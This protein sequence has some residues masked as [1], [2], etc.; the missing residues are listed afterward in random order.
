[1]RVFFGML[2]GVLMM[3]MLFRTLFGY[4]A[5]HRFENAIIFHR[6]V[7]SYKPGLSQVLIAVVQNNLEFTFWAGVPIMLLALSRWIRAALRLIRGRLE[8]LDLI[9]VAFFVTYIGVNVLGQTRGEAGRLWI[10]MVPVFILLAYDE[11]R[12]LFAQRSLAIYC[13]LGCQLITTFLI[14][15]FS[16]FF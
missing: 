13:L 4:N 1:M 16:Y 9:A 2:L 15:K 8:N 3:E 5:L 10:F 7:K 11:M 14:Y 12:Y 6:I